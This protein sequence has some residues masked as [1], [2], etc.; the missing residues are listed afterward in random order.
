MAQPPHEPTQELRDR[1]LECAKLGLNKDQIARILRIS[2]GTLEKYYQEELETGR[3][4]GAH[5]VT[6]S[7]F[8]QAVSGKNP[9]MTMF[10]LKTQCRWRETDKETD[11]GNVN[12]LIDAIKQKPKE[13]ADGN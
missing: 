3:A 12:A 8:R 9:A 4:E 7:A 6:Q 11:T 2:K 10:W 13:D 1:A 5:A